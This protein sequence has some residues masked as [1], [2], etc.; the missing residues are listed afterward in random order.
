M[1]RNSPQL[2]NQN[3]NSPQMSNGGDNFRESNFR[4]CGAQGKTSWEKTVTIIQ[5]RFP[6]STPQKNENFN[7]L[8]KENLKIK[9]HH[10]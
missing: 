8:P 6:Q 7:L 10:Q 9:I 4:V 2:V 1:H 5:I 3:V